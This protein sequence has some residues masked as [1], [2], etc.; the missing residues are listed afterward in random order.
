MDARRIGYWVSTGFIALVMTG[1][2]TVDIL[3][4]PEVMKQV[5]QLGFPDY[6]YPMLG[7]WKLFAAA[8]LLAPKLQRVKEWA[9][10][11]ITIDLTAA[12][13]AHLVVGDPAFNIVAPLVFLSIGLTSWYLRPASRKLAS[14]ETEERPE[15]AQ[16]TQHVAGAAR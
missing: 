9:Y 11:G 4:P 1:G 7:V 2:G 8:V 6:F 3:S 12:S 14:P 5:E 13:Y 10:A 15:A 16:A